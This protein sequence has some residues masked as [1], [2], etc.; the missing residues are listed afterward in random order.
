MSPDDDGFKTELLQLRIEIMNQ[1]GL[2][3]LL[4]A[5]LIGMGLTTT[6]VP[7][8][9]FNPILTAIYI[10]VFVLM[11]GSA[12][13]NWIGRQRLA[14]WLC[15]WGT[16]ILATLHYL[17]D[18]GLSSSAWVG[19]ACALVT[20]LIG[21]AAGWLAVGSVTIALGSLALYQPG[22]SLSMSQV[23][24][25]VL[26][27]A[28]LVYL[29]QIVVR[30]LFRTLRWMSEGYQMAHRQ[31][32]ELRNQSAELALA[33]KS[34]HQTSFAL[35]RANEQLEVMVK[36]AEDARQSKQEFAAS[37][38]HE[39]RAPLNLII[40]FSDVILNGPGTYGLDDLPTGLM[41]DLHVIQRNAQHLLKLVND[42]LDLSQMDVN[43]MTIVQEPMSVE[44]LVSSTVAD[45][46]PLTH[47][48]GLSLDIDVEPNLPSIQADRTRLRQVLLNLL[49]NALHFTSKGGLIVRAR[50]R[51]PDTGDPH[52]GESA[53]R[54]SRLRSGLKG[55]TES[56][57]Q[58]VV[59]SVTD[60]G[61]GIA[62]KDL[63]RTFEPFVR[64]GGSSKIEGTGLGLAISRRFV[65]LHGGRMWVESE[66]NVGSTF[67]FALPVQAVMPDLPVRS[68][69]RIAQRHEVGVLAVV[70]RQPLL[71]RLLERYLHGISVHHIPKLDDLR[72]WQQHSPI[73]AVLVNE[74]DSADSLSPYWLQALAG[75][76]VLHCY[77]P[78]TI[79]FDPQPSGTGNHQR[80]RRYLTK[81]V[82]AAQIHETLAEI[83]TN[84]AAA[85][86]GPDTGW[87]G[88]SHA[89]R[90]LIIE[91]DEDALQMMSRMLRTV[92]PERLAGFEMVIP[93]RARSGE[94]ALELL[95]SPDHL[96]VAG[97]FLDLALGS[98]SGFEVLRELEK[99]PNLRSIPMCIVSGHTV[100][101]NPLIAPS[102][103]LSCRNGLSVNELTQAIAALLKITL[104]GVNV[105]AQVQIG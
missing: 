64:L 35:A 60:T 45:I 40:G 98:M 50:S 93:V 32:D 56:K 84:P 34:L 80:A 101:D 16:L 38:S 51:G 85:A 39:L 7:P 54:A 41:A 92:P 5:S 53:D 29:T 28:G 58:E 15:A 57:A 82:T 100:S 26:P 70:E 77:V 27:A 31:A 47:A 76:P 4:V 3:I 87:P 49:N 21:P 69:P 13:L 95:R 97:I 24:A 99:D 75:I 63:Q 2:I 36:F 66:V 91:D 22:A 105:A 78:G 10:A 88:M 25:A 61:R 73:E 44:E 6:P 23:I 9:A 12:F 30:A 79:G 1:G 20:L 52:N 65:E 46:E 59:I 11:A 43:Y 72:I 8:T 102:L 104:P 71:S 62:V 81:P 14:L 37:V 90:V 68:T 96:P 55:P 94:Q 48:H 103:T 86:Q 74:P 17:A 18:T 33:L 89:A 83:L 19:I 67:Y 42:I